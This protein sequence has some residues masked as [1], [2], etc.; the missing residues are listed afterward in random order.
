MQDC[1]KWYYF[2]QCCN[3][4]ILQLRS[5]L[6]DGP[7][8]RRLAAPLIWTAYVV[9]PARGGLFYVLPLGPLDTFV[10]LA[11]WWI[12]F[13][14]GRVGGV[15]LAG[16]VCGAAI[17]A[18]VLAPGE[19]GFRARYFANADATGSFERSTEYPRANFTRID[20]R[21]DFTPGRN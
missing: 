6:L 10:L 21:L 8:L 11:V 4:T 18:S 19:P 16:A 9:W 1:R 7:S 2:L 3:P 13:V 14:E 17:L 20:E 15:R 5:P 12:A